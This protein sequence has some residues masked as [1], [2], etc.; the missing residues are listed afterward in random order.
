M[1]KRLSV[2]RPQTVFKG[3]G[4]EEEEGDGRDS[5][6]QAVA[7][8]MQ[9]ARRYQRRHRR[10]VVL[11]LDDVDKCAPAFQPK[12]VSLSENT[13]VM[14]RWSRHLPYMNVLDARSVLPPVLPRDADPR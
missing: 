7:A 11:V 3:F 1:R 6:D 9:G 12:R 4:G 2:V 13:L 8:L 14:T 5:I 10:P